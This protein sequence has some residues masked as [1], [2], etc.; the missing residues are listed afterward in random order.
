LLNYA[1]IKYALLHGIDIE[2]NLPILIITM[3]KIIIQINIILC[4]FNMLPIPPLDGSNVIK[5]FLPENI[6]AAYAR[7]APYGML[8]LLLLLF[9]VGFKFIF[10]AA[11]YVETYI[12]HVIEYLLKPLFGIL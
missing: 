2:G 1:F 6:A 5:W 8:I 3:L 7:L 12:Y 4:L 9:T 11:K 10:V